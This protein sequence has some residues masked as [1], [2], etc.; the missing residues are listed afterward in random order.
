MADD[1]PQPGPSGQPPSDQ[2]PSG[3]E[4]PAGPAARKGL[5]TG[6]IVALV[7]VAV[8]LVAF[9]TC[10]AIVNSSGFG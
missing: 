2:P 6:C 8:I 7:I 3:S 4:P 1:L 10:L 9:G 5:N